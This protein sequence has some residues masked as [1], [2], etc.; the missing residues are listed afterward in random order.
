MNNISIIGNVTKDLELEYTSSNKEFCRFTVAVQR[1]YKNKQTG[2]YEV[3]F[4]RCTAWSY[5][6]K[7]LTTYGYKGCKVGISGRLQIDQYDKDGARVTYA[8]VQCQNV[9]VLSK[10]TTNE[11]PPRNE[12]SRQ[13]ERDIHGKPSIEVS[14]DSLPF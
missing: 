10:R 9:E 3:D 4:I 5:S 2:D 8:S 7:H 13:A 12:E 14:E 6:A 1:D 11:Y